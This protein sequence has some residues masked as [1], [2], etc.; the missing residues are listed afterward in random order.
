MK[1]IILCLLLSISLIG[2]QSNN[3]TENNETTIQNDTTNTTIEI[4]NTQTAEAYD[5]L[6]EE[7]KDSSYNLGYLLKD[8]DY[9]GIDELIIGEYPQ[10]NSSWNEVIYDF[11]QLITMKSSI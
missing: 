1:K 6:I 7:A 4:T 5:S 2:C 3:E 11:I 8:I 10:E 9:N